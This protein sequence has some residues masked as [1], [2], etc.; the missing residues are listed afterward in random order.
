MRSTA[1]PGPW[2]RRVVAILAAT[3]LAAGPGIAAAS[4][5]A[6]AS[7]TG[8]GTAAVTPAATGGT[9]PITGYEGLCL[10]DRSASTATT[11]RRHG[12]GVAVDLMETP[13]ASLPGVVACRRRER[14]AG[15]PRRAV[16]PYGG[17]AAT[18]SGVGD[19]VKQCARRDCN[20]CET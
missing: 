20:T 11:R 6:A 4:Q 17:A 13:S 9:G 2:R 10:D 3:A 16:F 18:A 7:G 1:T 15:S 12:P 19:T 14:R 5:A 8:S